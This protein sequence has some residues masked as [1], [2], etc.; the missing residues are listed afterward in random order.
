MDT[1]ACSRCRETKTLDQFYRK[2]G[3]P[4]S[5]CKP[6]TLADIKARYRSKHP[7]PPPYLL[8]TEKA[9]NKCGVTKPLEQFHRRRS[10]RDGRNSICADCNTEAAA[11]F[12]KAHPDYH[13][14][15]MREWGKKNPDRKA[16]I[17]LK[18][19]LGVP[20]GTYARMLAEQDGKCGICGDSDPG[21]RISRFHVDHDKESGIVR[22]LL[23]GRCNTG[24]GQLRHSKPI[25][26]AAIGYLER[27]TK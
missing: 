13:R 11:K 8:P 27:T 24:I 25:L 22:G 21:A 10:S 7:E 14:I 19:R 4:S 3:R 23:C 18:V 20:H 16:D 9:C 1:K 12:N 6:C 26:L 15:K 2:E 17:Q 5:W